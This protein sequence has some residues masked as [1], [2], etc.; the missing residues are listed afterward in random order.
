MTRPLVPEDFESLQPKFDG[1]VSYL[2]AARETP[3]ESTDDYIAAILLMEEVV[4]EVKDVQGESLHHT[5]RERVDA[6]APAEK[7][8]MFGGLGAGAL[9]V[10]SVT[11]LGGFGIAAGGTA[12]G[13]A[14]VAGAAVATGGAGLVGAAGLYL[15][16]RG[17]EAAAKTDVGQRAVGQA[18]QISKRAADRLNRLRKPPETE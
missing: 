6:L 17:G 7:A 4:D 3:E 2:T 16:Y 1:I 14:G 12:F 18:R 11:G 9:S 10:L 8:A 13:V 5:F 15:L